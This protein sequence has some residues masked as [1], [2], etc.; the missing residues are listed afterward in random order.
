MSKTRTPEALAHIARSRWRRL[1]PAFL[2]IASILLICGSLVFAD[3]WTVLA[4]SELQPT[5]VGRQTCVECHAGEHSQ[6]QGSHHDLAMDN[7]TPESV[8]GNFNDAEFTHHGITSRMYRDGGRYMIRTEGPS[9][10]LEDFEVKYVFGVTPLQQ[11]MVEFDRTPE[12]PANEVARLQVLRISWD[13]LKKQWF[14]QP[15]PD[16]D[17]KLEPDDPLHW[18][19]I[20]QRWNTTCAECHSTNLEKNFD[21]ANRSYHTTFSEI[22][23]SCEACHGPGGAHVKLAKS[24]WLFWDRKHGYGLPNLK[25]KDPLVEIETCATC[26]S[27]RRVVQQ[28]FLPGSDYHDFYSNELLQPL[29]YHCDGQIRDEV[30]DYGSFIQSK[31]Y[32]KGIRCT[33]C[34]DPHTA[35]LKH[36]G[37]KVCTSCHQHPAGK[38]DSPAHHNHR[39]DS[40]GAQCVECHMPATTYMVVDPRRDH[41]LRVP[42]PDLSVRLG[43]P[44]ACTGC[45]IETERISSKKRDSLT[46]YADWLR[47]AEAGD[48]E[49]ARELDRVNEWAAEAVVEWYGPKQPELPDYAG[50]LKAAWEGDPNSLDDLVSVALNRRLSAMV[51][52]SA[53]VQLAQFPTR[54]TIET[55]RK[56]LND[57]DPQIRATAI[58]NLQMA[59][60]EILIEDLPPLLND[61]VRLVRTEAARTL[62]AAPLSELDGLQRQAFRTAF[63][64]F[65]AGVLVND[66][67][68]G[69]WLTVGIIHENLGEDEKAIVAYQTAIQVEPNVTGPRSNLAALFDRIAEGREREAQQATYQGDRARGVAAL[70]VAAEHRAKSDE[71]RQAELPLLRRDVSLA[72]EIA[73]LQYRYGMA[74]Y[75]Q[76][77]ANAAEVALRR[78]VALEPTTPEFVLGLALFF[79]KVGKWPEALDYVDRLRKLRPEDATYRQLAREILQARDAASTTPPVGPAA[80]NTG[81]E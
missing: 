79:Q 76:G 72:P 78:A 52:A 71:L 36:E 55:S 60:H 43:T 12:M 74:L 11:Y 77:D 48:Q 69:A 28:G 9:G 1:F 45:H 61:P 67:R 25:S 51:R 6:W 73:S 53:A 40:A 37:N 66:D 32:H 3:W 70:E 24:K 15:P 50:V 57:P 23:V 34:H 27:R 22:D 19:G 35:K 46:Q 17:G 21:V 47:L 49:I 75:L 4:P 7:A 18:T 63:E 2:L 41:S 54:E 33:D 42:R 38:Y 14:Y 65:K 13:T 5:Y 80:P 68:A 10:N 26:H 30:F 20:M 56:L 8:L 29:T 64:E 31:M 39:V 44:N 81:Q 58:A 59:P 62:S 16:V